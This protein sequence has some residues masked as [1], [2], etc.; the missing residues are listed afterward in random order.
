MNDS[1]EIYNLITNII[2]YISLAPVAGVQLQVKSSNSNIDY[3]V[4]SFSSFG[5]ITQDVTS[6]KISPPFYV[7]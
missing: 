3:Q 5:R 1:I 7:Q 2:M 4:K 6:N